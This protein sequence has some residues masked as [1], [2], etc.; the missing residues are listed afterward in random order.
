MKITESIRDIDKRFPWIVWMILWTPSMDNSEREYWLDTLQIITD[1]Q[2]TSLFNIL[3]NE[4]EK[5]EYLHS[6]K[7]NGML[8]EENDWT[9]NVL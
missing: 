3:K 2:I 4:K 1:E 5:L 6:I 9:I 8:Y 7:N